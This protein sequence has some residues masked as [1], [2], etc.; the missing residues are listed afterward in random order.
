[1]GGYIFRRILQAIPLLIGISLISFGVMYLAPGGPIELQLDPSIAQ[2]DREAVIQELGLNDP[3]YIQYIRWLGDFVSGDFGI[4]FVRDVPVS[5]LILARLPNTLLLMGAAFIFAAVLS[6]PIGVLAARKKNTFVDNAATFFAFLGL[7]TP[8]FWLGLMLIMAFAV[9]LDWLP[10]GGAQTLNAPFSIWDRIQHLILP[11]ITLGTA[12]MAGLTR[13]TRASMLEVLN[14]DY[15]RT[16]RAK[17]LKKHLVI[18]KHGLRNG[19]IPLVTIF[20]LTLPVFF[21]GA[22]LTEKVFGWPGIGLLF[23]DSV[24][25]RDYPVI[26][27]ITMISAVLVVIGNLIADILYALLDPRINYK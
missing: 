26:M 10:A 16:A 17:G 7:A 4:S 18:Y 14:Q 1:M 8:N 13:Y 20:G 5:D 9:Y 15:M 2:E 3:F 19:L 22:V 27:G 23:I 6:I 24:F 11:M 21:G 25:M 12:D